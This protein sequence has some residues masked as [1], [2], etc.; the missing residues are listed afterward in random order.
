MED[1]TN[2]TFKLMCTSE[3]ADEE[4]KYVPHKFDFAEKF[5]QTVFEGR[6]KRKVQYANV[7][8]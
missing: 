3:V 1:P 8:I 7:T 6:V 5:D 4:S 2:P